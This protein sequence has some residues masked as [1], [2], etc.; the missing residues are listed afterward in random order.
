M[1]RK[2]IV[3]AIILAL[4]GCGNIRRMTAGI[5]GVSRVCVDGVLYLQF[6]S[7]V[8]VAFNPDG[9]IRGC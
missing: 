6:C 5:T 8:T 1:S 3:F 7:G 4:S 2:I 9:T